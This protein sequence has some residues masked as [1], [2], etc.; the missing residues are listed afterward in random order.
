M[1]AAVYCAT[2]TTLDRHHDTVTER[3]LLAKKYSPKCMVLVEELKERNFFLEAI[4]ETC[5]TLVWRSV[6]PKMTSVLVADWL[7]PS[8]KYV[9]RIG[10]RESVHFS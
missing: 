9:V 6:Q 3:Q 8:H 4:E 2:T 1:Y 5:C 7:R 10:Y